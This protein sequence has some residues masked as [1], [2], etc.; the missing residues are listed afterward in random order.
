[1]HSHL[2]NAGFF[3]L[4]FSAGSYLAGHI[5]TERSQ[6]NGSNAAV[7][8]VNILLHDTILVS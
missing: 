7:S 1:M 8:N 2:N 5:R 4:M 6:E 3:S